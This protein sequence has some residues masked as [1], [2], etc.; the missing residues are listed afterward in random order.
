[1]RPLRR[2]H[3]LQRTAR[4]GVDAAFDGTAGDDKSMGIFTTTLLP[5]FGFRYR[6]VAG[7]D[8]PRIPREAWRYSQG[9]TMFSTGYVKS[10][11]LRM[12]SARFI[13]VPDSCPVRTQYRPLHKAATDA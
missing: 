1:M 13:S 5:E 10:R 8:F 7:T 9:L 2:L 11:T 6:R 12:P 4:Q 3:V